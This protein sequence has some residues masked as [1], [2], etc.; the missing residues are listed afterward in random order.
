MPAAEALELVRAGDLAAT[1]LM[2]G[3]PL[4]LLTDMPKDGSIRL[5]PLPFAPA[6]EDG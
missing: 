2:A 5:L 1:L 3:K 6:L 4:P